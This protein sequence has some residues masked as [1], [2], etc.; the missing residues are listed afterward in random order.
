MRPGAHSRVLEEVGAGFTSIMA[1]ADRAGCEI[2]VRVIGAR[3]V[4]PR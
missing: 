2:K 4:V 1:R 3:G